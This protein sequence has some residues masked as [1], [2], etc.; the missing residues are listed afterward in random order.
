[1]S[2]KRLSSGSFNSATAL[3]PWITGSCEFSASLHHQ[4]Q[5]GHGVG[6]VDHSMMASPL[7]SVTD[8]KLQFGHGVG[9]VDHRIGGLSSRLAWFSLQFGHGVGAVDP[10]R[11][12]SR[13]LGLMG[14][15]NSATALVPWITS[16][17]P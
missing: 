1:I 17:C 2:R 4:L 7:P 8:S 10:P 6:A 14:R 9:A 3:V 13:D 16:W 15:F 12:S 5:F 11:G